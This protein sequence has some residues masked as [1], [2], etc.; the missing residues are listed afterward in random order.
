LKGQDNKWE[1]ISTCKHQIDVSIE[2]DNDIYLIECKKYSEDPIKLSDILVLYSRIV[3]IQGKHN[4]K[5]K[6]IFFTT[7]GYQSGAIKFGNYYKIILN[8]AE[9]IDRFAAEIAGNV[10]LG[11]GALSIG[12]TLHH[13]SVE[14][15]NNEVI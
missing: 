15:K 10:I 5:I 9:S 4:K 3:D 8:K 6:G 12:A 1:G 2:C 11:V 13:P 14:I 7:I